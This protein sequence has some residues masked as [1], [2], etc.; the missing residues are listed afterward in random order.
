MIF[1]ISQAEGE[2]ST[3]AV[4]DWLHYKNAHHYRI[5]GLDAILRHTYLL[6][7]GNETRI[8][9]TDNTDT[10]L[11]SKT[12]TI[13]F[14]RWMS[15]KATMFSSL[16][17]GGDAN[18]INV[19]NFL[20]KENATIRE[21]FLHNLKTN[22]T[23]GN[24]SKDALNKLEVLVAAAQAGMDIPR[25]IVT[26]SKQHLLEFRQSVPDIIVKSLC[27]PAMYSYEGSNYVSYTA[28]FNE[29]QLAALPAT[30]HPSLVQ[31]NIPKAYELRV[32]Y[33][34]GACYAM[35]IFSQSNNQTA[36]DFR[37]YDRATPNRNVPYKLPAELSAKI[38]RL[39]QLIDLNCGSI[40]IVR[41]PE[42]K[43]YFLEVNPV[44]QFGMVSFPCNY[45][46]EEKI[47]DW[48][49]EKDQA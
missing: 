25:S 11:P 17:I 39:M 12:D 40:D 35:A 18:L 26:S 1:I 44:G 7:N 20:R 38:G 31:E 43:Y 46:L 47:A 9:R 32:F 49:I 33:L 28:T 34:D 23:L 24:P 27:N 5:N 42:G 13:W 4:M 21:Y 2:H 45:F 48:L 22:K 16:E 6:G 15:G 14:R 29:A 41:T 10:I 19:Y 37:R 30:F 3:V 36:V 8:E